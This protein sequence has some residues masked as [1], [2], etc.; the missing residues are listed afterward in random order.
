MSGRILAQ[1]QCIRTLWGMRAFRATSIL[2]ILND[3]TQNAGRYNAHGMEG[4]LAQ[5]VVALAKHSRKQAKAQH[6]FACLF[7]VCTA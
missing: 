1:E 7:T 2:G 4:V 5:E 6:G 3:G